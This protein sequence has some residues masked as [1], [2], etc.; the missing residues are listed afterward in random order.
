MKGFF[1]KILAGETIKFIE[2]AEFPHLSN[3][4]GS[5]HL[6]TQVK[7][8]GNGK[9]RVVEWD[10]CDFIDNYEVSDVSKAELRRKLHSISNHE[11]GWDAEAV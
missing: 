1:E 7:S 3:N 9:F 11:F 6:F 5:F 4:G 10:S 8:L 2:F